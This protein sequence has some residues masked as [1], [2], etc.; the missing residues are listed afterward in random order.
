MA[1]RRSPLPTNPENLRP[2][3][4]LKQEASLEQRLE[5]IERDLLEAKLIGYCACNYV[6]VM[7]DEMGLRAKIRK[8]DAEYE[9]IKNGNF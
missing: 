7:C 6:R 3:P 4:E 1:A 5:R 2:V 8:I 9:N